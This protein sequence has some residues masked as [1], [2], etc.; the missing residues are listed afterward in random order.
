MGL[1]V[2][3]LAVVLV[4]TVHADSVSI[5]VD[6]NVDS[7]AAGYQLCT[8]AAND[9]SLR[10]AISRANVDLANDYTIVLPGGTY[11]LTLAG[12]GENVNATGDL[13]ILTDL[14]L[15]GAG[16]AS[17]W[18][19]GDQL[20]RVLHIAAGHSV[21]VQGVTIAYG[22]TPDG[23]AGVDG[24]H[25][26]GIYNTGNLTLTACAVF[27]N[28]TGNGGAGSG[29]NGGSGG[30]GGGIFNTG[31]LT[32]TQC[33][34]LSNTTGNGGNGSSGNGG[35]GGFGGGIYNI[36]SLML[37]ETVVKYNTTG[38]GGFCDPSML[39]PPKHS[40]SGGSGGGIY[41]GGPEL[42]DI[43]I[44]VVDSEIEGNVT[45]DGAACGGSGG[46]GGYGGDGGGIANGDSA[47]WGGPILIENSRIVDNHTG[48]G[49]AQGGG[50]GALPGYG[51]S[52]G[53]IYSYNQTSVTISGTVISGNTTGSG[54][55]GVPMGGGGGAGGGIVTFSG[56][57]LVLHSCTV[58][59]NQ[60][61][62][63]GS[64][65]N[66]GGSGGG[67]AG[68]VSSGPL[69]M[70]RST[71]SGNVAGDGGP[72]SALGLNTGNAGDGGSGGGIACGAALIV[73]STI[74]GN[75]TG[76][77]GTDNSDVYGYGGDGGSGGG[78]HQGGGQL[79]LTNT[80][81][82]SNTCGLPGTGTTGGGA[83][84]NGGGVSLWGSSSSFKNTILA[85][86]AN[87]N[88]DAYGVDCYKGS[89]TLSSAGY[90]LV[91]NGCAS[92]F[93]ATA[94]QTDVDPKLGL[95]A[96]NGGDTWTRALL[97]G[98]P[99]L[100]A[101][102]CPGSTTD[103]RGAPRPVD[104]TTIADVDDGCDIGAYEA[105]V[106]LFLTKAVDDDTPEVGQVV[107]F[108]IVLWN[109]GLVD[110]TS[111]VVY[112]DLPDGVAFLGPIELDPPGAG[113]AG[114]APPVLAEGVT[115]SGPGQVTITF[116][117]EVAGGTSLTNTASV[118]S[119]EVTVAKVGQ[120]HLSVANA[121]PV[122]V[123]DDYNVEID[124]VLEVV[125]PGVL[126]NDTDA[127][128]DTLAAVQDSAPFS[129]TLNFKADGSFTYTPTAGFE[130][131]D[132][133]TYH[134][135]DGQAA[136]NS[137]TVTITVG[138]LNTPPVAV[139][140]AY[141]A[142][143]NTPLQVAAPGVLENDTDPDDDPLQAVL[144]SAPVSGTL[145]LNP[146]G[147]FSYTPTMG[148]VGEDAFSYQ[149]HDG[150]AHSDATRV[151]VTVHPLTIYLPIVVRVE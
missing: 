50:S 146:D 140:D 35:S 150:L 125:A 72:S 105:G 98:S 90:N 39:F 133:F 86:N 40:G 29:S 4:S 38:Q 33:A 56:V 145:D 7:N 10:G 104:I 124:T 34:V 92:Y 43:S 19:H 132:S 99:A 51:G 120:V 41:A 119:A 53:G 21:T 123:D 57:P 13:D 45:G 20:D 96:D 24:G 147:S 31:N 102:S 101:G 70:T 66:M 61:G 68:I 2:T 131:Q 93:A 8:A 14:T 26:G 5:E 107:T 82:A 116:P 36:G 25:G 63:G 135:H 16:S 88:G 128:G 73:D 62:N 64:G 111:A 58:S 52:G 95:L 108:T 59:D 94:D 85:D 97:E 9:C 106:E 115:I 22:K 46:N 15:Q 71:V 69:T 112:D 67:G 49:A 47:H 91:E 76:D 17:T 23:G 122:A 27:S 11:T 48:D 141:D 114:T 28:T 12:S 100:D 44:T 78:L 151:T 74:N 148:F 37:D 3:L 142:R 139:E 126:D 134:A 54:A 87:P 77:A 65:S 149:A 113:T 83:A 55:N 110:A 130:G 121:P 129:G 30:D 79:T 6:T 84:G 109:K 89:S 1:A 60:T 42:A 32:L 117:V 18:I 75:S 143:A 138:L 136:S 144:A 103:Q 80:T 127:N 81:V 118:T 137:A